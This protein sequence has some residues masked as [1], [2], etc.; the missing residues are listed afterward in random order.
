MLPYLILQIAESIARSLPSMI[1]HEPH[2]EIDS[3]PGKR[4]GHRA[5]HNIGAAG[6]PHYGAGKSTRTGETEY[7]GLEEGDQVGCNS[8][9]LNVLNSAVILGSDSQ[10]EA[11]ETELGDL[12]HRPF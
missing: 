12:M 9:V 1:E 6:I 2:S 7:V 10:T 3:Q 5:S 11:P 8:H 4:A